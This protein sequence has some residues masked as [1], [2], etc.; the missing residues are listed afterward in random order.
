MAHNAERT[1]RWTAGFAAVRNYIASAPVTYAWL[2]ILLVTTIVQHRL[3][4]SAL[5]TVLGER[6]TNLAHLA[7]DPLHVLV[8]SLFWIDGGRWLPYLVLFSIF[9]ATAERWLGAWRWLAVGLTAHVLATYISEGSLAIAIDRGMANP[10]LVDTRDI[11]VSYFLAGVIGVLTYHV[12]GR[13]R[14]VY[15][16]AVLIVYGTPLL[17]DLNFTA[18]GH[19]SSVLIGLAFYPITRGR[20]EPIDPVQVYRGRRR[21]TV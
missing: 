5:N 13:W 18:V 19:F 21:Q 1:S 7:S 20:G 12:A 10:A 4:P 14:W 11:G 9:H 17:V 15:L 8:S 16:A 3:S 2:A 6:S